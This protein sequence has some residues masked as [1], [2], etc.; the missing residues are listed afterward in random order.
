MNHTNTQVDEYLHNLREWQDELKHLRRIL[1]TCPLTEE[2]KWRSPCYTSEKKN[3]V[4]LGG[5]KDSCVLS[6]FKGSLLKDPEGILTKPGENTREG[7]VIRF[8]SV[9]E[10][11]E[12]EPTLRAYIDEAIEAEKAGLTVGLKEDRELKYPEELLA[13][14]DESP[15]LKI[16]FESLTPGR[17]RAYLM[18]FNAAKQSKTKTARIEKYRER[19]LDGKGINDCTCG[20]SQ[21]MPQCDGSHNSLK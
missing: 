18:F 8:T 2:F 15:E 6:F 16:A 11:A 5:F 13:E 4:I 20:L 1:L 17:Q 9:C 19:I 12:L 7:R 3:I 14:L 21:K 10:I